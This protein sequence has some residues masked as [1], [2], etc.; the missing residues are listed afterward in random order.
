MRRVQAPS[1]GGVNCRS[2]IGPQVLVESVDKSL[3][4]SQSFFDL[5]K[6]LVELEQLEF[7]E[8]EISAARRKLHERLD[9]FPNEVTAKREQ[10]VSKERRY[11]HRRIDLLRGELRVGNR[12]TG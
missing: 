11:L 6:M 9:A 1:R 7:R 10:E 2:A 5:N 8:R 3:V 4:A 12:R